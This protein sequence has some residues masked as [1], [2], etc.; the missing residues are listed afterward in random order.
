MPGIQVEL[1]KP[2]KEHVPVDVKD[3]LGNLTDLAGTSPVFWLTKESDD[4][5]TPLPPGK[6]ACDLTT[7][8]GMTAYCLVDTTNMAKDR[9][10]LFIQFQLLPEVP[11]LGPYNVEVI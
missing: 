11:V 10:E 2:T 5:D 4:S 6:Q 1:T 8:A 9:Y 3:R 7:P